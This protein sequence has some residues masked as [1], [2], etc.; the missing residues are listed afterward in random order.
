MSLKFGYRHLEFTSRDA[1]GLDA[2]AFTKQRA[3]RAE[4]DGFA[5]FW[6]MDHFY[7]FHGAARAGNRDQD[8]PAW[9]A[10]HARRV[11]Q[12]R[13]ARAHVCDL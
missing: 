11:S 1:P 9:S 2:W 8:H 13:P 12:S 6:L 3:Q 7:N 5:S 4:A 10:G